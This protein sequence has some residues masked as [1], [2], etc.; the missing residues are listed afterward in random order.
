MDTTT[1]AS[2]SDLRATELSSAELRATEA[3]GLAQALLEAS[4]AGTSRSEAASARRLAR[5]L[6]DEQGRDLLLNL[7]DQVMRIRDPRRAA[8]R[9]ADMTR[10]GVPDS[11]GFIDR[12]GLS[13]LG[14]VAPAV[15][16]VADSAVDW[17]VDRDTAGVILP[18]QDPAFARYV[19]R[20][21]TEGFHLN[22]NLLG[23]AILSHQE[24]EARCASVLERIRRPDITYISIKISAICANLDI[25]AEQDSLDR[26]TDRLRDLYRE[27]RAQ[28][29]LGEFPRTFIN[30]D[31][32]E[33]RD[34][35][36][37]LLSFMQVL[38]EPEF[39]DLEAGIVLQAYIPDS[40]AAL[41]RLITWANDRHA[42][43]GAGIKIRLVKGA[44]LAMEIVEAE[45]HDWASACYPTKADVDA[46]YKRML[47]TALTDGNQGAVRVGVASHN[48]FEVAWALTLREEL[49][50]HDRIEIEMLEGMAPPQARAVRD[51]AG[52]LLLYSPVVSAADRE[53]SIA[54]LSRRLD[55]N[56]APENFLRAL[57]TITPGSPEW[58]DQAERFHRSV[59]E[60]FTVSTSTRRTQDRTLQVP[61]V[62]VDGSFANSADT[63]FTVRA[64]REWIHE[65]LQ[66][67][68]PAEPVTVETIE[69][70]DAILERAQSAQREWAKTSWALR[71]TVLAQVVE[72]MES[73]RGET[74]ALMAA[75]TG[76]TVREGDPEVSEAV[77]FARYAA[78]LTLAHEALELRGARWSP[79]SVVVVAGPWN[80]PYA[81]PASGLVHALAAG[82][83]V[84]MKPAPESRAVA[85]ALVD[86]LHEAGV[87]PHLVQLACTPDNE[88][89]AHLI[90]H[91]RAEMVLLTG[92]LE[93]ADLFMSW[94][95][96]INIHAET[97]G[98][99]SLIITAAA[100][101][102][103]AI[104]DLVKSA[105][106]H[107]GQKCSAASLAIIEASVYDDPSFHRR[108]ADAVTSIMV[109][110]AP[111][112]ETMMGPLIVPPRG[113]LERALTTLEPG[114]TWLVEPVRIR[115]NVWTPGVRKD[116]Q[117]GSWFHLTECFGPV[118]G[119]IRAEDL[120]DAITIANATDYGL[121][122]GIHSLD[123][124]EIA[125]WRERIDV[126]NAYVNRH[127]TGA[128][129]QR[130]PF[131]GWKKSTIGVG[132]KPG[133]P[134]HL[135]VFG[136]WTTDESTQ[137]VALDSFA[138]A[139]RDHFT[140]EHDHSGLS[141]ESNVLRYRPVERVVARCGSTTGNEAD[142][143][144]A[145]ARTCGVE[146]VF[147]IAD[148]ES[149]ESL[150]EKLR[151][152]P[153]DRVRALTEVSDEL[154]R[155]CQELGIAIDT[156]PV[157]CEGMI[158]LPHWVKEQ[159]ISQTMH[160][161]G[162]LLKKV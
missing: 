96:A 68:T 69:E 94:K 140:Q 33:Y 78:H 14:R 70:V 137:Q 48:L 24:A 148:D 123:P 146:L 39:F 3:E 132:G 1:G 114:E 126:G 113:S 12:L 103:Q 65:H 32:E 161:Y 45:L 124:A 110:D 4:L 111:D 147:S 153:T 119:L 159:S 50:A 62:P 117:P 67:A 142:L 28:E 46:S 44:N 80:F 120:D 31:M 15:P 129:V 43:G 115:D 86:H 158:E 75:T 9:L 74:I 17:R 38:S 58:V 54:Y 59:R 93:T 101:V 107:A 156:A 90:T 57:F 51:A 56:S 60:S 66:R 128:I 91:P 87:P 109:G 127:I 41:D 131:G 130:Q 97:S 64:N 160:R 8:R 139:W 73:A 7:T 162:R 84:I 136:T 26:V 27:A 52:S 47:R 63:D 21:S 100:D 18:A 79:H 144:R 81:I 95:P 151:M 29:S 143:L 135:H 108:L 149:E 121:T 22:I 10:T 30:L 112:V 6:A 2:G 155:A 145:A 49:A 82:S 5:L 88:V 92:S 53:A 102:D 98:K 77:D 11:L 122:G 40:H 25:L 99:N 118:L 71:R 152:Q 104:K 34:L 36:L 16:R 55:E 106:G 105:F 42:R 134:N 85:A 141:A 37:S 72:V 61:R 20:R 138:Q 125:I 157:T 35:E 23:E 83:A 13:M 116:V 19:S 89:G 154:L 150:I 133:G 76:K